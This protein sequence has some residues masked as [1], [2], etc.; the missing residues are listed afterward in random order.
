VKKQLQLGACWHGYVAM[1]YMYSETCLNG[2]II[3]FTW[4]KYSSVMRANNIGVG[5]VFRMHL[6]LFITTRICYNICKLVKMVSGYN[7]LEGPSWSCRFCVY[8]I[9]VYST[10]SFNREV[11]LYLSI[12]NDYH[13][14]IA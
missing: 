1:A 5:Y 7:Y 10:F 14:Y 3:F 11:T 2:S 4:N 6:Y 13:L 8:R 12:S 9:L